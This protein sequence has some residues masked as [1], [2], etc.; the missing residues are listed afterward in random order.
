MENNS[1]N[2]QENKMIKIA[3][4]LFIIAGSIGAVFLGKVLSDM[5]LDSQANKNVVS[6]Q[7]EVE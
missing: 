6:T 1:S 5:Y 2:I 3:L 7:F 4:T